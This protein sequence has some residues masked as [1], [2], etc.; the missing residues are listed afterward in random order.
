MTNPERFVDLA[1]EIDHEGVFDLVVDD[2]SGDF[3]LSDDL[4]P[5]VVVSLF[6]DRRAAADEVADPLKRRGWL[7]TTILTN[8]RDNWGSGIWL[9]EQSRLTDDRAEGARVEAEQALG[10]MVEENLAR[11]V[12]VRAKMVPAQRRLELEATITTREGE[13][14]RETFDVIR[15][16]RANTVTR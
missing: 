2:E 7:G 12:Q 15:N 16:T 4:I 10:W 11:H 5:S 9:Y 1:V 6:T 14:V 3:A 8:G 13:V